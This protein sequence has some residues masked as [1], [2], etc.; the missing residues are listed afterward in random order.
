[1]SFVQLLLVGVGLL[2]VASSFDLKSILGKT[3]TEVTPKPVVNPPKPEPVPVVDNKKDE[4]VTVVIK[5]Q[6]L[7]DECIE[8]N[9]TEAVTKLD[10]I[11]PMLIKVD[12]K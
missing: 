12:N 7:K 1:M 8:N 5:W 6:A 3:K 2:I 4:L 11:F 10:E 9:L